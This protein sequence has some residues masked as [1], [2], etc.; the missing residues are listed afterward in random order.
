MLTREMLFKTLA[1]FGQEHLLDHWNTLNLLQKQALADQI[2]ALD[3]PLLQQ[4]HHDTM[5]TAEHRLGDEQI[6]PMPFSL[7]ADDSR[8]EL[9][10]E[11]GESLL[12]QGQAAA[13]LVAGGQGSRLGYE[14]P[15]GAY[16]VGLPS[17]KSIFQIQ[18]ERLLRL[19]Q[20][21]GKSIPWC[22]MTS[23]LNHAPTIAHFEEASFFGLDPEKVRFFPQA[24]IPAL[25]T[26]GKIL[27]EAPDQLALVP[28]GN[29]GCFR[30]L[31]RSGALDWL[32]GLGV[33]MVFL[34][35]VD[36]ILVKVC[37]PFFMG[38]LAC[39]PEFK[40]ASKVVSKRSASEKVGIF[41]FRGNAPGVIEYSDLPENLREKRNNDHSLCFDG[42]NIAV[43]LFRIEALR[44]LENQPLPWHAAFK[45]VPSW[46]SSDGA[47]TALNPNAWKFEQFLFDSFPILGSM[48]PF[49]V[50][51]E[52]E[53][54]PVKNAEGDDSP[55][56]SRKMLGEL[57]RR[58]L[59]RA[60]IPVD[61]RQLFEISPLIS[62]AGEGL[63]QA[64]YNK[65]LGKGIRTFQD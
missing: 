57:H 22:I 9:W 53:F 3:L 65:E 47:V 41:A 21:Y 8:R 35:G 43:H 25:D 49:G 36:N 52:D 1:P 54:A 38:A 6:H 10:L 27:L 31:S 33:R 62:Y 19:E 15:K 16:K 39:S 13:F 23:P 11:A 60:G 63:D 34:Y 59:V 26:Q 58:W 20:L 28:D 37:D 61:S 4:L 42:G 7:A 18:A 44:Q 24:M 32:S 56:S 14:G 2:L 51:R 5:K 30:A 12:S 17:G 64:L 55:A 45:K 40:S 48:L 46:T 29:G 50:V